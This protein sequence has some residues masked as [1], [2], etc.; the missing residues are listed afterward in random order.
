M[1]SLP[2]IALL[3]ACCLTAPSAA[4]GTK[5]DAAALVQSGVRVHRDAQGRV[6]ETEE[7]TEEEA[8]E[9]EQPA[10]K[11]VVPKAKASAP[12]KKSTLAKKVVPAKN[13]ALARKA[14]PAKKVAPAKNAAPAKAKAA[15]K[16]GA[17]APAAAAKAKKPAGARPLILV[18]G[19]SLNPKGK[20]DAIDGTLAINFASK[21]ES[22]EGKG[23]CSITWG[24]QVNLSFV[25]DLPKGLQLGDKVS[26]HY[27]VKP[28]AGS[29]SSVLSPVVETA[30][31]TYDTL[32]ELCQGSCK[33][34]AVW[35]NIG[36]MKVTVPT[37][38][39]GSEFCDD[40]GNMKEGL[41]HVVLKEY[42]IFSVPGGLGNSIEQLS[43]DIDFEMSM[44]R[45]DQ[46]RRS[47]DTKH[48]QLVPLQ[49]HPV[50]SSLAQVAAESHN[51]AVRA[52]ENVR[53]LGGPIALSQAYANLLVTAAQAYAEEHP[54]VA[55]LNQLASHADQ[56]SS[57]VVDLS[58]SVWIHNVKIDHIEKEMHNI[59]FM[60]SGCTKTD[61]K[62]SVECEFPVG[63]PITDEMEMHL[64]AMLERGSKLTVALGDPETDSLMGLVIKKM[65]KEMKFVYE[66]PTCGPAHKVW[67]QGQLRTM[68]EVKCGYHSLDVTQPP[69]KFNTLKSAAFHDL[70]LPG[71]LRFP[72]FIFAVP[73]KVPLYVELTHADRTV[74]FGATFTTGFARK[75]RSAPPQ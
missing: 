41:N 43:A 56:K 45:K 25:V 20:G 11:K 59:S 63:E 54:E 58:D 8:N 51:M 3:V 19:T 40:Q 12:A 34:E 31:I 23:D 44:L 15:H 36:T 9:D 57:G 75:K 66:I 16:A 24:D 2:V 70:Y 64:A 32:C 39:F 13:V 14:A 37:N 29:P 10:V 4:G 49:P 1:P 53:E 46:K 35:G 26:T 55:N 5:E 68:G 50:V 52:L 73:V 21:G 74:I 27:V 33:H 18:R 38:L 71:N 72:E 42:S 69:H 65:Y 67:Y 30:T 7:E 28:Q 60:A 61:S 22:C 48:L 47:F 17:K 6:E 62:G